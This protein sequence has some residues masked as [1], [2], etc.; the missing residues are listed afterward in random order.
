MIRDRETSRQD[1]FLDV[2]SSGVLSRAVDPRP[3]GFGRIFT[4]LLFLMLVVALLLAILA[5]AGVYKALNEMRQA[6]DA[7]R[8]SL[9]LIT[10]D[11]HASDVADGFAVGVGPEGNALVLQEDLESGCYETRIY[12]Y[13][14]T[15]VEEYAVA[16]APY[17]PEKA[18]V[19]TESETFSFSYAGGL[20]TIQTDQGSTHVA[21]RSVG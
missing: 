7:T 1:H 5:G 3:A 10:N 8:L 21:L 4:G 15:I 2:L 16:G 18:N 17:T 14:G 20:L 6:T 11:I 13:E 19:L 12:L 9:S